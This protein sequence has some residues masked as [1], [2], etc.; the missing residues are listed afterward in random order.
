[1]TL[2]KVLLG[3][4]KWSHEEA[5][6]LFDGIADITIL[7]KSIDKS[8]FI[9]ELSPGGKYGD[10][11]A[12]LRT[13]MPVLRCFDKE[14][15]DHLPPT[16]KW[17]ATNSA[18]YDSL[19][20]EALKAK[21][22]YLSNTPAA[23][24]DATATTALY[25]IIAAMRQ[26]TNAER[27][28]RDLKWKPASSAV[29]Y[30]LTGKTLAILG[31]GGIGLRIAELVH[32]FPMRVI[33]HNR[34]KVEGAPEYCEYF[35]DVEEM[36]RQADVLSISIPLNANTTGIVGEK[37]I[38]TM[39]RGSIIVNTARGGVIDEDALIRA[40][41]DGHL[42]SVGLDVLPNEPHVNP[43]ILEFPNITLLPHMGTETRDTQ[44]KMEVRALTNIRDYLVHG[45]GK[46]LIPEMRT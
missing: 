9:K 17:I 4:I 39:K 12:I 13:Y 19:D 22:I 3:E 43:R 23:V 2:P 25:L 10:I 38:R 15:I 20:V 40:L 24:D 32:A 26:F 18:G 11:V 36:L 14:L 35:E 5:K 7:D 16:V 6:E 29:S 33:Y 37:W 46:D 44:R 45:M 34:R 27:S 41:E 31:L 42:G 21:G 1:M 8:S 28:L 30:D